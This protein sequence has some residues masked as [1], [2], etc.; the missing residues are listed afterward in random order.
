MDVRLTD[1]AVLALAR[2]VMK[3]EMFPPGQAATSIMPNAILG[4]GSMIKTKTN[5][6]AGSSRNC[7]SSPTSAALGAIKTFL[8]S[9]SLMSSAIPNMMMARHK[10]STQSESWLKFS[11][12]ES[13]DNF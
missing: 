10:L 1:R 6:A 7:N 12:A 3:L 9:S 4:E 8:K 13:I 2:C 11:L 5:V